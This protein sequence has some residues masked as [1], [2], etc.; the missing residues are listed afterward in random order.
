MAQLGIMSQFAQA[1]IPPPNLPQGAVPGAMLAQ[2]GP[3]PIFGLP[4]AAGIPGQP[5]MASPPLPPPAPRLIC[6][7]AVH[8]IAAMTAYLHSK[9]RL[10]GDQ[11]VAWLKIGQ[12]AEPSLQKL[13]DLCGQLPSQPTP[14]PNFP[15]SRGFLRTAPDGA[16][17]VAPGRS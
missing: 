14:P 15:E 6:E 10:Q 8:R 9:L 16:A 7:E 4:G 5:G 17:G 2:F 13:R 11:E 12:A 1:M 3:P